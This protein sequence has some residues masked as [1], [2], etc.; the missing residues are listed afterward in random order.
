MRCTMLN[1]RGAYF[2]CR[3]GPDCVAVRYCVP[4][5]VLFS[6]KINGLQLLP[7]TNIMSLFKE[8]ILSVYG[9]IRITTVS[10]IGKISL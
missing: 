5:Q 9:I 8:Q 6:T 10:T 7:I 4:G 1:D 3:E 2:P